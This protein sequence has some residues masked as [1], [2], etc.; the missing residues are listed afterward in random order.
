[1]GLRDRLRRL[2]RPPAAEP[3]VITRPPPPPPV[4]SI[5]RMV[6]ITPMGAVILDLDA[7]PSPTTEALRLLASVAGPVVVRGEW[8]PA[9]AERLCALGARDVA[10]MGDA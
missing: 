5:P 6:E 10:W 4:H 1:M 8:A 2:V 7:G 9:V 3:A